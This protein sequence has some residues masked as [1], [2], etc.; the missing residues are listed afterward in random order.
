MNAPRTPNIGTPTAQ[1]DDQTLHA[2]RC[3]SALNSHR[4]ILT[5][6]PKRATQ[7]FAQPLTARCVVGALVYVGGQQNPRFLRW[8]D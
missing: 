7:H 8:K 1:P 2:G 5:L 4:A 6:S 3:D